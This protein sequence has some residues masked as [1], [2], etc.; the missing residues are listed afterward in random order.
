[1]GKISAGDDAVAVGV[2]CCSFFFH[3]IL[4]ALKVVRCICKGCLLNDG[5]QGGPFANCSP[6]SAPIGVRERALFSPPFS[7]AQGNLS[8]SPTLTTYSLLILGIGTTLSDIVC[9]VCPYSFLAVHAYSPAS[10]TIALPIVNTGEFLPPA[11]LC[12]R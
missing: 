8:R 3:R 1:M 4:T 11:I 2:T 12:T 7:S 5:E 10:D 9:L 6:D